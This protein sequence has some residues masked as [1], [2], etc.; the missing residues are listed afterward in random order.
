MHVAAAAKQSIEDRISARLSELES[1][2]LMRTLKPPSGIDFCSNDYLGLA[3]DPR[4]RE[5]MAAAIQSEGCGS[6]GSRLIRGERAA[7]AA[8]ERRFAAF[9][10]TEASLY[11]STGYAANVGVL[12]A[13]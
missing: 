2:G 8:I 5:R 9:K 12:S 3:S 1:A 11:F 4:I 13:L 7:F 6:T 10:G